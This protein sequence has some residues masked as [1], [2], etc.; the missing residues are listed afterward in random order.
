[1]NGYKNTFEKEV[2]LAEVRLYCFQK[3]RWIVAGMLIVA[4]S[5]GGYKFYSTRS[6]NLSALQQWNET[7]KEMEGKVIVDNA[8]VSKY[9]QSAIEEYAE[10]LPRQERYLQDSV[11]MQM[12]ANHL[13]K[14][15]MSFLLK[16]DDAEQTALQNTLVPAYRTYITD[17]RLAQKICA[18]NE[19]ISVSDLQYLISSPE[20]VQ[21]SLLDTEEAEE[22]TYH[23]SQSGT[24]REIIQIQIISA[25]EES[26]ER[27]M[28]AALQGMQSYSEELQDQI[29]E[30]KLIVLGSSISECQDQTI[31]DYQLKALND[32]AVAVRNLGLLR[33]EE[34]TNAEKAGTEGATLGGLAAPVLASPLKAA[35]KYG[36]F[37]LILG[38][39]LTCVMLIAL[40]LMKDRLRSTQNFE[41]RFG[42][43]LLGYIV[44][45]IKGRGIFCSIDRWIQQLGEGAYVNLPY[46][47][48]V[49]MA[50]SNVK[51]AI[52]PM[53]ANVRIMLAGTVAAKNVEEICNAV[54]KGID[55]V[56]FSDYRQLIFD[57]TAMEELNNYDGILFVE[58]K[59]VSSPRSICQ[60]NEIAAERNVKILG[61]IVV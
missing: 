45:P 46:E 22:R 1:M 44:M 10:A 53:S 5:L 15:I 50:L 49:R 52:L 8:Y 29:G 19:D 33:T 42:M 48:Q 47:E 24:E 56:I 57:A 40:F 21:T 54:T 58:K 31:R 17:G 36:I 41:A 27:Y 4:V 59:D 32:Y 18:D 39:V 3:W 43:R 16:I 14:G 61:A 7:K 25:D 30:H 28:D 60:E 23:I 6:S 2:N 38:V 9:Y 12:D 20:S 51:T 37:G 55:D 11:F 26:C 35:L 13:Q 34:K